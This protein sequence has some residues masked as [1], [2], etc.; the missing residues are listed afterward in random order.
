M[1]RTGFALSMFVLVGTAAWAYHV[2]YETAEALGRVDRIEA[3]IA[4]ERERLRVLSVEWARLNAPDRLRRLV[5]EHNDRLM[6]MPIAADHYKE[7]A[8]VPF[9]PPPP[10]TADLAPAGAA[11]EGPAGPAVSEAY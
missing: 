10:L 5:I 3:E 9:P 11:V 1:N 8:E 6:L 2:N 7:V 4:A